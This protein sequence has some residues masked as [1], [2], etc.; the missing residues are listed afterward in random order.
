M[1]HIAFNADENYIKYTAVLI[2]SIVKNTKTKLQFKDLFESANDELRKYPKIDFAKLDEKEKNEGYVFHIISDFVSEQNK[3][4]LKNL[5]KELSKI[6]PCEILLHT[7]NNDFFIENKI[8][9]WKCNFT[10]YYSLCLASFLDENIEKCLY[11]DSDMLVLDDIRKLFC[12]DISKEILATTNLYKESKGGYYNGGFVFF[13]LK[14]WRLNQC[15]NKCLEYAKNNKIFSDQCIYNAVVK[16]DDTLKLPFEWNYWLQTFQSDD[17]NIYN[18]NNFKNFIKTAKIIHYIRPK[19][20]INLD[21]WLNH[22]NNKVFI[23]QNIVDLW[24]DM[25]LKTPIFNEEFLDIRIK[26]NDLLAKNFFE[27]LTQKEN[28]IQILNKTKLNLENTINSLPHKIN[29]EKLKIKKLKV[30]KLE[31]ELNIKP[32]RVNLYYKESLKN[33]AIARIQNHLAYKL[34]QV[35]IEH[36][37]SIKGLIRIP[38]VLSYIKDKHKQEQIAYEKSIK[39]NPNLKL[40]PLETYGD[41][42]EALKI[43]EHLSYKLGLALIKANNNLWGGG[44]SNSSLSMC[45]G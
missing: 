14:L 45:L 6:Y 43:K 28:Q 4:K 15:E 38:Y 13:N 22:S 39:E 20:W 33:S 1:F 12:L 44:L 37:K 7:I 18:E 21:A 17:W 8:P 40:L 36:S 2:T 29:E 3:E 27:N 10:T 9:A 24:W 25:A 11:L 42:E 32:I 34:G 19:P 26:N 30:L 16:N 35:M 41:Y 5:E 31:K 23:Y